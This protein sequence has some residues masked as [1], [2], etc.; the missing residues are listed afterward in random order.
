M[1]E[2]L[3]FLSEDSN[4]HPYQIEKPDPDPQKMTGSATLCALYR[5]YLVSID[6]GKIIGPSRVSLV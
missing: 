4:P 1:S 5:T 3:T 2:L 6:E